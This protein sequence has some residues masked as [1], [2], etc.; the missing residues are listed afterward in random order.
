MKKKERTIMTSHVLQQAI[1]AHEDFVA[2]HP[3]QIRLSLPLWRLLAEG[4][5]VSPD[6]LA[7]SSHRPLKEIQAFQPTR[8]RFHLGE[9]TLYDT[10][11]HDR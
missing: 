4:K 3:E 11:S 1:K 9:K 10:D 6:E 8:H 5:P 7:N 2:A